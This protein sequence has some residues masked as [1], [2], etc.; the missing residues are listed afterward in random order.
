MA[1]SH[2]AAN[3]ALCKDPD[4]KI[5]WAGAEIK[6][7]EIS[8]RL[9]RGK[10]PWPKCEYHFQEPPRALFHHTVLSPQASRGALSMGVTWNN[11]HLR[12]HSPESPTGLPGRS[13]SA[14]QWQVRARESKTGSSG[15]W[16]NH[17]LSGTQSPNLQNTACL[18]SC[19]DKPRRHWWMSFINGESCWHV[20]LAPR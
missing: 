10:C 4:Q 7:E 9:G 2:P 17:S 11:P 3:M 1:W 19:Q 12:D 13:P 20:P 6:D 5:S 16:A 14:W 15:P 8:T 18:T